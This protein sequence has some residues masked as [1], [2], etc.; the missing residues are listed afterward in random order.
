MTS[1]RHA[2]TVRFVLALMGLGL[3]ACGSSSGGDSSDAAVADCTAI[4]MSCATGTD[5]C[6]GT[7]DETLNV[8]TRPPGSCLG[9]GSAC[10][11]GAECCSFACV[12]AACSDS[13]CTSDGEACSSDGECCGGSCTGDTCAPLNDSCKTSGNACTQNTDC[14]SQFCKDDVCN[15]SPSY[16]TQNGDACSADQ[17]CCGGSCQKTDG[18]TLGT[19]SLVPASGAGSCKSAGEVC[20]GV[21]D[22]SPLP[23]CGGECCSRACL[24]FGPTGVLICQPPSGCRPTGEVCAN[25][26]DCCGGPGNPDNAT[27]GVTCSKEPGNALGRCDNGRSCTPAG[28][29]C[30]LQSESCNENANCCSGNVL[31]N[32][33]CKRDALGIP[34]CLA[35]EIDCTDP[36]SFEGD[37]CATSADCCGLPCTPVGS[38]EFPP[39][40]CGGAC[41]DPGD[42]C[43]TTSDCCSGYP[44]NIPAGSTQGTCGNEQGCAE[45]GQS[46]TA[47]ADCCSGLPCDN[48]TCGVVI[49]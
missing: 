30:R 8:C 20:G 9:S 46:C 34:R 31:Q 33:T 25:D 10:Q 12:D 17:E 7:C 45:F 29:I 1:Q 28:G 47:A 18:A 35:A 21:W 16:C 19:C 13:Q 6:T 49:N 48:G 11:V 14:C 4:G 5:C 2:G 3:A 44:C 43:T 15:P 23:T 27:S 38:G 26:E 41:A 36:S 37:S 40:V 22:G 24:P 39:L 42:T 32:N